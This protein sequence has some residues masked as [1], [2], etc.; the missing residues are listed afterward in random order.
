MKGLLE[1]MPHTRLLCISAAGRVGTADLVER[2][3]RF[4]QKVRADE[5]A[6]AALIAASSSASSSSN[7][8]SSSSS[9][10]GNMGKRPSPSSVSLEELLQE[11]DDDID[12][13]M[14]T[15]VHSED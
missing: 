1:L 5:E 3:Y 4:L 2:T 9:S 8:P 6:A 14:A 11:T 10:I 12:E 7:S 13:K 15:I